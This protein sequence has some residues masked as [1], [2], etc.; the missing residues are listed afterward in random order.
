MGTGKGKQMCV[1]N[2]YVL[3]E[4]FRPFEVFLFKGNCRQRK[5]KENSG[6][7]SVRMRIQERGETADVYG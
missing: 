1:C 6:E 2:Q 4:C 5:W 7:L 3:G